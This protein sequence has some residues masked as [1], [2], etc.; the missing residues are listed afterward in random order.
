MP[1][2]DTTPRLSMLVLS[3]PLCDTTNSFQQLAALMLARI[4]FGAAI[5]G[6]SIVTYREPGV[7]ETEHVT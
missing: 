4:G 5:S 2:M 6:F 3:H 7:M 1:N